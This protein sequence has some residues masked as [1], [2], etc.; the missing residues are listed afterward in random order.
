MMVELE[1][2]D[3]GGHLRCTV[4]LETSSDTLILQ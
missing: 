2:I 3:I 4:L 1:Y